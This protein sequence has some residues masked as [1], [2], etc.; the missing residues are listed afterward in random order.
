MS[1]SDVEPLV[2]V[3]QRTPPVPLETRL[4]C[5]VCGASAVETIPTD[6]C[7]YFYECQSCHT[8]LKPKPGQ[9]CVFCSYGETPCPSACEC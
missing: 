7:L 9:C 4:T 3:K 5:P 2:L 6:R 1:G 8:V